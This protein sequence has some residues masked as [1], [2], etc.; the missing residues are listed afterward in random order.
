MELQNLRH[1]I[2]D[3]QVKAEKSRIFAQQ[4]NDPQLRSFLD[5]K[6]RMA[7]QNVQNMLQFLNT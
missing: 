1:L 6:A 2:S 3:E 5:K 4:V 7:E